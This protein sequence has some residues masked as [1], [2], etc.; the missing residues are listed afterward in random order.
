M[1]ASERARARK[2]A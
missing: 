2:S 1:L